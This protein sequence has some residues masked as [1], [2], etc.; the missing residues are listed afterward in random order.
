MQCYVISGISHRKQG[1]CCRLAEIILVEPQQNPFLWSPSRTHSCGARVVFLGESTQTKAAQDQYFPDH[2]GGGGEI[3]ETHVTLNREG[4]ALLTTT[5][6]CLH[7]R[8]TKY[9]SNIQL[10]SFNCKLIY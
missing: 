7:C 1:R 9:N 8:L 3:Q 10:H 2:L 4:N 5:C 6:H